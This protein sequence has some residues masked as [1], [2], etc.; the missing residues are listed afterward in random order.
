METKDFEAF[1]RELAQLCEA[2]NRPCNDELVQS[3]WRSLKDLKL[4]EVASSIQRI[5]LSGKDK[6]PKPWEL[7]E[8]RVS[9]SSPVPEHALAL[10]RETWREREARDKERTAISFEWHRM[11]RI[12]AASEMSSVEYAEAKKIHDGIIKQYGDPRYWK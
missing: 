5:L 12:M 1:R 10:N 6:F 7:R 11:C 2:Y 4:S 3:Y 8:E 9:A